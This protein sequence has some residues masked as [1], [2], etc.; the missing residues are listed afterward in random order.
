MAG[1]KNQLV[2]LIRFSY[3]AHSG[4]WNIKVS[5]DKHKSELFGKKRMALRFRLF[6]KLTLPSLRNQTDDDF[7]CVILGSDQMPENYQLKL[8]DLIEGHENISFLPMPPMQHHVAIGRA[9]AQAKDSTA[10]L[11]TSF[12]L[13][14]DDMLRKTYIEDLK[15][16][17]EL[18][19]RLIEPGKPLVTSFNSGMFME[20]T[21]YGNIVYDVVE[22]TP[23]AQGTAMTTRV[24][25]ARNVFTRNHRKLPAFFR[26]VSYIE[27]PVWLR[28]VHSN[29]IANPKITGRRNIIE[30]DKIEN[31]LE[32]N[33]G[34]TMQE[35]QKI[36]L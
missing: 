2:G 25:E 8:L 7:K 29:N 35:I 1:V 5:S 16:K 19:E 9:L 20:K 31:L 21:K 14:D 11:F 12:R 4:G 33:F 13:D 34:L 24:D 28:T 6:E 32:S 17:V 30:P 10:D 22:R 27:G 18:A 26:T 36:T 3:F 15:H 23:G